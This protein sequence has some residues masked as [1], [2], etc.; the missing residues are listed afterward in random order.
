MEANVVHDAHMAVCVRPA[1][2]DDGPA[3]LSLASRLEEGVSPWRDQSNVAHAVRAWVEASISALTDNDR[4]CFVA[5]ENT[6]VIGFV[7]VKRC[8]HWS[9]AIEAYIGELMVATTAEGRGVGRALV[10][11]AVDWSQSQGCDRI[12]L[13]TGSANAPALAFYHSLGFEHDEVRLSRGL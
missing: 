12:A 13:E 11:E 3:A 4:A 10:E 9:G 5:E 8:Q 1:A 6:Q 2:D 7:S